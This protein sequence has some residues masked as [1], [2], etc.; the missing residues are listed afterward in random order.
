MLKYEVLKILVCLIV[1]S[2]N[3]VGDITADDSQHVIINGTCWSHRELRERIQQVALMVV[4]DLTTPTAPS[5]SRQV[6]AMHDVVGGLLAII[7][8]DKHQLQGIQ[9]WALL[10]LSNLYADVTLL[11]TLRTREVIDMLT[12]VTVNGMGNSAVQKIGLRGLVVLLTEALRDEKAGFLWSMI[13]WRDS[14][15][16]DTTR[17]RSE[18]SAIVSAIM[19][20]VKSDDAELTFWGIGLLH[21]ITLNKIDIA[22]IK[23]YPRVAHLLLQ[24]GPSRCTVTKAHRS[25]NRIDLNKYMLLIRWYMRLRVCVCLFMCV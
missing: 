14:D 5:H 20:A 9:V 13:E 15:V 2:D 3:N 10:V 11:Q 21:E 4:F 8:K 1:Q 6:V 18:P 23:N 12:R 19:G 7:A 25:A 24:V 22:A 16:G 17:R